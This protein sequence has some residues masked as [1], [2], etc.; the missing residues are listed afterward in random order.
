[1]LT[2]Q[3]NV[4]LLRSDV[5]KQLLNANSQHNVLSIDGRL[6]KEIL[7]YILNSLRNNPNVTAVEINESLPLDS[8]T[9]L[10]EA[11]SDS[12]M[13]ATVYIGADVSFDEVAKLINGLSFTLYRKSVYLVSPTDQLI[14]YV[15]N[16]SGEDF[17]EFYVLS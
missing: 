13:L 16:L 7:V 6:E 17:L 11:I 5:F 3:N 10:V 4:S 14:E 15:K 8:L 9:F 1:M 12:P 2:H